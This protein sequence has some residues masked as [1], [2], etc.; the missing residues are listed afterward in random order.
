MPV[1]TPTPEAIAVKPEFFRLPKPG[2]ADRFFGLSRSFYYSGEARGYWKLIR[3]LDERTR[4]K[5]RKKID[6]KGRPLKQRGITLIPYADVAAFV[7]QQ[8]EAQQ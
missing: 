1:T 7:R 5:P 8:R 3:I 2:E 6:K 4:D